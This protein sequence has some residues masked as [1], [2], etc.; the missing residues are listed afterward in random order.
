MAKSKRPFRCVIVEYSKEGHI[1]AIF[2]HF[3]NVLDAT[4]TIEKAKTYQP[5]TRYAVMEL[6][7]YVECWNELTN[8][9]TY[10]S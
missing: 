8:R 3:L 4:K 10:L 2:G 6:K 5:H 7:R 1:I 9:V